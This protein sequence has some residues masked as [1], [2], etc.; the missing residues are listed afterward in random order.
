LENIMTIRNTYLVALAVA[1]LVSAGPALAVGS[2][3]NSPVLLAQAT[4]PAQKPA[5]TGAAVQSSAQD[6]DARTMGMHMAQMGMK[7]EKKGMQMRKGGSATGMDKDKVGMGMDNM[8]KAMD[9]MDK[10]MEP[11]D[12]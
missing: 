11:G 3:N 12:M 8:D 7:M 5:A 2:T 9:G 6:P 4:T 10:A 1:G